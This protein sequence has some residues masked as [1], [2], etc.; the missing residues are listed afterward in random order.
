MIVVYKSSRK[1]SDAD[2]LSRAPVETPSGSS[3]DDEDECFLGP[4][5]T[6]DL[7]R[8]QQNDPELRILIEHLEGRGSI[9]PRVFA[10]V[11]PIFA[12]RQGVLYKENFGGNNSPWLLLPKPAH[13]YTRSCHECQRREK[14]PSKPA[15]LLQPMAPPIAPFQQI[16]M[17][18]LG[19]FPP[20]TLGDHWITVAADYLTRYAETKALPSKIAVAVAKFFIDSIALRHGAPKVLITDCGSS[21][22]SQMTQEILRLSHTNHLRNTAYHHQT[23][24][25]TERLNKT[26]A[27]MISMHVDVDHKTWDEVLPYV[28]FAYNTAVQETT[29]VTPFQL[30][31][32]RKVTTMLDAMLPHEPADDGSPDAQVV[33]RR[34]EE[35]H[36]LALNVSTLPGTTFVVGT[37]SSSPE[38]GAARLVLKSRILS[39]SSSS[40]GYQYELSTSLERNFIDP[41]ERE[42]LRVQQHECVDGF[43]LQSK[44]WRILA[45][46]MDSERGLNGAATHR[47]AGSA[48]SASHRAGTPQSGSGPPARGGPGSSRPL[49]PARLPSRR[50]EGPSPQG[51]RAWSRRP[52]HTVATWTTWDGQRDL[53]FVSRQRWRDQPRPVHDT[54][55]VEVP[56]PFLGHTL[57][58]F[59]LAPDLQDPCW[60]CR[61]PVVHRETHEAS[62]RHQELLRAVGPPTCVEAALR[63]LQ[64][65]RPDLLAPAARELPEEGPPLQPPPPLPLPP[66]PPPPRSRTRCRPRWRHSPARPN[67][68]RL[69]LRPPRTR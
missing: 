10:R 17:D 34:A 37:S 60:L 21:F 68:S 31:Q 41:L 39:S 23:N 55:G 53:H 28:T 16:G 9:V 13:L 3:D 24:G 54:P 69:R 8:R 47:Q 65:D 58:A 40:C 27:D 49:R 66:R 57:P 4:V 35:V 62:P 33:A 67:P 12:V 61:V 43:L 1:H 20:S 59:E 14:P 18:L 22:M 19:V 52:C 7:A 29:G 11:L 50:R 64:R 36:Q 26:I 30:V 56:P 38:T 45:R 32:G 48:D 46:Q 42:L 6:D 5:T 2:C 51:G 44:Q 25:L 15:G 63:L